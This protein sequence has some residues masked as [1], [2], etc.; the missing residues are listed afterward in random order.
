[1]VTRSPLIWL[2]IV[3][4]I[5]GTLIDLFT[6]SYFLGTGMIVVGVL[7]IALRAGKGREESGEQDN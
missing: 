2:G 5:V 1:M 6:T 4:A 3:L 7:I